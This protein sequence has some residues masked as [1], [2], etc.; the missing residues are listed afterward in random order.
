MV[1]ERAFDA[2]RKSREEYSAYLK[3]KDMMALRDSCEKG[4]LAV[5]LAVDELL[6][7][8]GFSK[9][10]SGRERRAAIQELEQK[11]S[12]VR[13]LG[14]YDRYGAR[15]YHL[16]AS[17]FYEGWLEVNDVRI[18]LDKVERYLEDIKRLL[19]S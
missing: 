8:R 3:T 11:E 19:T 1:L 13:E 5:A 18:E 16:H 7:S 4:W 2:L 6:V 10:I 17:G 12:K 15:G 14:I 9:P